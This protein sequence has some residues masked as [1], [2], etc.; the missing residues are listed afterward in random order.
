MIEKQTYTSVEFIKF[1][2]AQ[3]E[4]SFEI[5][6]KAKPKIIVVSNALASEFFGKMKP[7]HT[8]YFDRI[9]RGFDLDF[10]KDFDNELGC[11]WVHFGD[12]K[13]PIVF[14]GML[15]G[16]RALDIGSL[17]RLKWQIKRILFNK[18][19]GRFNLSHP[20]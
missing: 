13:I 16:Q 8:K 10:E 5:I 6:E 3:L 12:L 11:Y 19:P 15:S 20:K 17:E 18:K 7:K 14:S 1:I 9:W 4:I 2:N